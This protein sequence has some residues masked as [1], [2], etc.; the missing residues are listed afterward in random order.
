MFLRTPADTLHAVRDPTLP[1]KVEL[2]TA[3]GQKVEQMKGQFTGSQ[4]KVID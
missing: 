1:S 3:V 4:Q 2:W